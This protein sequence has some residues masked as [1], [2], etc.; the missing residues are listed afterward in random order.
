M[1]ECMAK[2]GFLSLGPCGAPAMRPCSSCGMMICPAHLSPASGFSQCLSCANL[3]ANDD[4]NRRDA[5]DQRSED[6]TW[7]DDPDLAY[8]SRNTY[9]SDRGFDR[10]DS[11]SFD[12]TA[13]AGAGAAAL[14]DDGHPGFGDS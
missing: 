12:D 6:D 7:S 1:N 10:S 5:G 11:R 13:T 9:Y 2:R 8:R 14:D 4:A 3:N